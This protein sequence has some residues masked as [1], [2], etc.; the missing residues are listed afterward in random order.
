[1]VGDLLQAPRA[2][3]TSIVS[4]LC[5]TETLMPCIEALQSRSPTCAIVCANATHRP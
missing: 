5:R 2:R 4:R 3:A 1:M